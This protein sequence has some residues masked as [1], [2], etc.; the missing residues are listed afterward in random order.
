MDRESWL[1]YAM[2]EET[3]GLNWMDDEKEGAKVQEN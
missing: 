1:D 3:D 2:D